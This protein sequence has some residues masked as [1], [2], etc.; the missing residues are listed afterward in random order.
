[1]T[2]IE[3]N[4]KILGSII[5]KKLVFALLEYQLFVYQ[6]VFL[7]NYLRILRLFQITLIMQVSIFQMI[8]L[9]VKLNILQKR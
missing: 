7:W 5:V 2:A 6:N 1:M 4:L 8:L 3:F 9:M